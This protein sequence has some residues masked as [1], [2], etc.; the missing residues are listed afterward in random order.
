MLTTT[1]TACLC[2]KRLLRDDACLCC[3]TLCGASVLLGVAAVVLEAPHRVLFGAWAAL[4]ALGARASL[5]ADTNPYALGALRACL[6]VAAAAPIASCAAYGTSSGWSVVGL[7]ALAQDGATGRALP[8]LAGV[9][10]SVAT[11]ALALR[12]PSARPEAGA[13]ALDDG[14]AVALGGAL[15]ALCACR[16]WGLRLVEDDQNARLEDLTQEQQR[17]V[18]NLSHEIRTPLYGILG[19]AEGAVARGEAL[20]PDDA[21]RVLDCAGGLLR[22]LNNVIDMR[23]TQEGRMPVRVDAFEPL[24]TVRAAALGLLPQAEAAGVALRVAGGD[25]VRVLGDATKVEQIVYNLVSNAI[26]FTDRGGTVAV[27]VSAAAAAAPGGVLVE[28]SVS[29]NGRGIPPEYQDA[30][31]DEFVQLTPTRRRPL[32]GRMH[33]AG[34][35]LAYVRTIV[36]LLGGTISVAS[37]GVPGDGSTFTVALPMPLAAEEPPAEAASPPVSPLL[38]AARLSVLVVDDS[39][40]STLV[41]GRRLQEVGAA[42]YTA[43]DGAEAVCAVARLARRPRARLDLVL[44]DVN[45][46]E[47]DGIAATRIIR[48]EHPADRLPVIAITADPSDARAADCRAAGMNDVLHKPFTRKQLLT[49]I[50]RHL[51]LVAPLPQAL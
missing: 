40:I 37:T 20:P 10:A 12:L 11:V 33:G 41:T 34:I 16:R 36:E 9:A 25:H 35:G 18:A 32:Y 51:R 22:I 14:G 21:R 23:R 50:A 5:F 38:R 2:S 17:L 8:L 28:V 15:A 13:R 24:D 45:L 3:L 4:G 7:C 19:V 39:S 42:V 43:E 46:K 31:F 47:M 26:K 1:T 6:V 49:C 29:D 27:S 44:M 30:I 48:R